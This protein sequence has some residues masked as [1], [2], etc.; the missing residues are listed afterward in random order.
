MATSSSQGVVE[1]VGLQ[2]LAGIL[3]RGFGLRHLLVNAGLHGFVAADLGF[4]LRRQHRAGAEDDHMRVTGGFFQRQL[5]GKIAGPR[6]GHPRGF[7]QTGGID[8]FGNGVALLRQG[9]FGRHLRESEPR[10]V[11]CHG[12]KAGLGKRSEI[13]QEHVGGGA[14]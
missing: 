9:L 11:D 3:Q 4:V 13:A 6:M 12:P 1:G 2:Q 7:A 8:E 14:Q 10:N 5:N